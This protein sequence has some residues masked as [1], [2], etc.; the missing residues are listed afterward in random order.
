M[1]S[2]FFERYPVLSMVHQQLS[3]NGNC[4]VMTDNFWQA[5]KPGNGLYYYGFHGGT[6]LHGSIGTPVFPVR[7][8]RVVYA[9]SWRYNSDI[10]NAYGNRICVYH[11]FVY[12]GNHYKLFTWYCHLNRIYKV[13][14][15]LVDINHRIGDLGQTGY[16]TGPHVHFMLSKVA[17][18]TRS[19][20]RSV[21]IDGHDHLVQAVLNERAA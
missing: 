9:T 18:I 4:A 10:G 15:D 2:G 16:V 21:L 5:Y 3:T 8:G 11:D 17:V 13:R 1:A 19:N 12:G 7:P 20:A 6:D 14:G